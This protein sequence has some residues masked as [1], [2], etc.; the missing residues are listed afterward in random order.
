MKNFLVK[1]KIQT[2]RYSNTGFISI[3]DDVIEGIFTFDYVKIELDGKK[4]FLFLK[5]HHIDPTQNTIKTSIEQ[6][7]YEANYQETYLESPL[8]YILYNASG[9]WLSLILTDPIKNPYQASR[10]LERLEKI[11]AL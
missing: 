10:F 5:E 4:M 3:N 9:E 8:S 6:T 7:I 11:R 2:E 1:A